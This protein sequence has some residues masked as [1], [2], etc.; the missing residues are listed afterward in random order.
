[1]LL[2]A[3]ERA[4]FAVP[5]GGSAKQVEDISI[6]VDKWTSCLVAICTE[7][8]EDESITAAYARHTIELKFERG[9]RVENIQRLKDVYCKHRALEALNRMGVIPSIDYV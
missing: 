3:F 5:G 1:M 2:G 9:P 4:K 8:H 7:K 6:T